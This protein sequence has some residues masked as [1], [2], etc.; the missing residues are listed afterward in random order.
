MM[1]LEGFDA[2]T[3]V[4]HAHGEDGVEVVGTEIIRMALHVDAA[5][6]VELFEDVVQHPIQATE[7]HGRGR[8]AADV[9]GGHRSIAD[10]SG[11]DVNLAQDGLCVRLGQLRLVNHFVVG[12]VWA[13]LVTEGNMEIKAECVYVLNLALEGG[14]GGFKHKTVGAGQ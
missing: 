5:L 3:Q 1:I 14:W 8:A 7:E 4:L 9:E 6:H 2:G 12:T 10:E 13:D 11:V